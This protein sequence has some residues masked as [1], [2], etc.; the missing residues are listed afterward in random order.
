MMLLAARC[1]W[2]FP[3]QPVLWTLVDQTGEP[4]A[5]SAGPESA[6]S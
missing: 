3:I 4:P 5:A 2:K 6:R 1:I